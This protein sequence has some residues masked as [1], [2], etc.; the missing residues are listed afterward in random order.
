MRKREFAIEQALRLGRSGIG[1]RLT[2]SFVVI[3]VLMASGRGLLLWQF[4]Q[5]RLRMDRLNG[6]D[7][8]LIAVL[9]FQNDLR[10][11]HEQLKELTASRDTQRVLTELR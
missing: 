8:E 6:V 4:H 3:V 10:S 9:R 7:E 5:V 1:R 2:L 11:F